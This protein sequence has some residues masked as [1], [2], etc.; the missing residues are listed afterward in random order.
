MVRKTSHD[1][2]YYFGFACLLAVLFSYDGYK[3]FKSQDI[4]EK[5]F[6]DFQRILETSD[7]FRSEDIFNALYSVEDSIKENKYNLDAWLLKHEILNALYN[8]NSIR[9]DHYRKL[10]LDISNFVLERKK[11]YWLAWVRHGI[12]L[13]LNGNLEEA[14]DAFNRAIRLAPNKFETNFYMGSFLMHFK[15]RFSDANKYIEKA[16]LIAP[17]KK[18]ALALYQKLKL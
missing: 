9:F 7:N 10:M 3:V 12:S 8:G 18:E 14:E 2:R 5:S 6:Y 4:Y 13:T 17:A 16:L 11:N 15:D 1:A